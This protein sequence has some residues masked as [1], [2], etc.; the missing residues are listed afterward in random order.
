LT[1]VVLESSSGEP[2]VLAPQ[3]DPGELHRLEVDA[4]V[5]RAEYHSRCTRDA[6]AFVRRRGKRVGR[7]PFFWP[8]RNGRLVPHADDLTTIRD[9][10]RWHAELGWPLKVIAKELAVCKRTLAN[11]HA[12]S[13]PL[14]S[15][16]FRY[17]VIQ[18]WA[19]PKRRPW[20]FRKKRV[21]LRS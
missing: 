10:G 3:L 19:P 17:A 12:W 9:I 14:V 5:A 16:A 15:A 2:I 11:G 13:L 18:D 21:A 20:D 6:L 8:V 7:P 4:A 1:I